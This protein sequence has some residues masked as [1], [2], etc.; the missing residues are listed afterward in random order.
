[1]AKK[2]TKKRIR[3]KKI[4]PNIAENLHEIVLEVE[5]PVPPPEI[6]DVEEFHEPVASTQQKKGFWA[7]LLG[8]GA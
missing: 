4:I 8:L 7:W 2:K 1:M 3:V 6:I 5:S